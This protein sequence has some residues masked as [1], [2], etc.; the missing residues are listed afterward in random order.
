MQPGAAV[1]PL[2]AVTHHLPLQQTEQT[3]PLGSLKE[4][5]QS[6]RHVH[7]QKTLL[8]R[9]GSLQLAAESTKGSGSSSTW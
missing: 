8:S 5:Q 2:E 4:V 3:L 1:T 7:P 9:S 6:L